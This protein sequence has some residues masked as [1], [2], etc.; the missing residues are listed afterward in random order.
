MPQLSRPG[1]ALGTGDE[2]AK[3]LAKFTGEVMA[4]FEET[5]LLMGLTRVKTISSGKSALF[6]A[7]GKAITKRH[8]AGEDVIDTAGY[9]SNIK[10]TDREIFVDDPLTAA[11]L[12]AD[13]DQ[14]KQHWEARREY[15]EQLGRALAL[16]ADQDILATIIAA[17]HADTTIDGTKPWG[18]DNATL[19]GDGRLYGGTAGA[20]DV[21]TSGY[22]GGV[23]D[24]T[25]ASVG[26]NVVKFA[27]AAAETLDRNNVP[28]DDR[29]LVLRP[30]QYY[31]L[32]QVTDVVSSDFTAAANGGL[33]TGRVMN[34]AGFRVVKSANFTDTITLAAESGAKNDLYDELTAGVT[35]GTDKMFFNSGGY[36]CDMN[37]CGGIAFHRSCVGTV[38][39]A[40]IG[41]ETSRE[42]R[43]RADLVVADYAMGHNILR[44]EAACAW[45][46]CANVV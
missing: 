16:A 44:P 21:Y 26:A 3:F 18:R 2:N 19:A 45:I 46:E 22:G 41:I 34:V 10:S 30:K 20:G 39:L 33:D 27:F 15:T 9:L 36:G 37:T 32:A 1:Q 24:A 14:L 5:N 29:F 6:A 12:V 8:V 4:E 13:I 11:V 42:T 23:G 38:K 25:D 43:N 17:A 35:S 40:D 7:L 31:L 28:A